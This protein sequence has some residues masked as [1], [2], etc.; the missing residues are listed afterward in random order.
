[1][2]VVPPQ[3]TPEFAAFVER[4]MT[5]PRG[6]EAIVLGAATADAQK[7]YSQQVRTMLK[8]MQ[9]LVPGQL[10]RDV[11][12]FHEKFQLPATAHPGHRIPRDVLRFRIL[13]MLEELIEYCDSVGAVLVAKEEGYD[14]AFT[15]SKHNPEF[16]L[17]SLI[18]L[19][20]VAI[21]T[22]YLHRFPFNEGWKL[23]Q[24]ANMAKVRVV[25]VE[26][27]KRG[28]VFDVVKP[29]GWRAPDHSGILGY[30]C[31]KCGARSLELPKGSP[32]PVGLPSGLACDGTME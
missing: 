19:C 16:A 15:S 3:G 23:V 11:G 8:Q 30:G 26:D 32:C 13:F 27:S 5:S 12:L 20:Y 2:M 14:V 9:D 7:Q 29:P 28:S 17:D 4:A 24:D 18:D 6:P 10:F 21:G 31:S 1:M 25:N 22:A